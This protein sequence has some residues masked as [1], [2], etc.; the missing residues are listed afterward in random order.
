MAG[1]PRKLTVRLSPAALA[2]LDQIW[3]WNAEKYNVD[4]AERYVAFL[5]EQTERLADEFFAGRAVPTRPKL[6]YIT[7]KRSR[8]AHGH[9]A[10]YELI[11]EAIQVLDFFH[12]AQDWQNTLK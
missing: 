10:V 7:I 12:T 1:R 9:V 5:R 4:H 2:T 11:G 3:E 6:S 8:K